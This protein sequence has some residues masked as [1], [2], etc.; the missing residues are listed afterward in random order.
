MQLQ[1]RSQSA[2]NE[3]TSG[4]VHNAITKSFSEHVETTYTAKCLESS[5]TCI[6]RTMSVSNNGF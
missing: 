5:T 2:D 3:V 6:G 1:Q 4:V